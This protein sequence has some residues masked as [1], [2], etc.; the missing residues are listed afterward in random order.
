MLNERLF[1][2]S[3]LCQIMCKPQTRGES[4]TR[5][6]FAMQQIES[7]NSRFHRLAQGRTFAA[8]DCIRKLEH[9]ISPQY[10][11]SPADLDLYL[12]ELVQSIERLRS[13]AALRHSRKGQRGRPR[14][15]LNGSV[16]A[17]FTIVEASEVEAD[18][19]ALQLAPPSEVEVSDERQEVALSCESSERQEASQKASRSRKAQKAQQEEK[20]VTAVEV[21]KEDDDGIPAFLK[22]KK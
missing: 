3:F 22:R 13:A 14:L 9:L 16:E 4:S 20:E 1:E 12:G 7:K 18:T 15:V 17:E 8:L 10:E 5:E 21:S 11:W 6:V 2:S 19:P